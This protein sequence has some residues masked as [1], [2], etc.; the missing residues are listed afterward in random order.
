MQNPI[1][2]AG[3]R[4]ACLTHYVDKRLLDLASFSYPKLVIAG[5]RDE[6]L[7]QPVSSL[8]LA[9]QLKAELVIYPNGGHNLRLQDPKWQND[10][11]LYHFQ[12]AIDLKVKSTPNFI[13][14]S[15][16]LDSF[17]TA[18]FDEEIEYPFM[19]Q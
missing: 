13:S 9:K 5:D 18:E 4:N 6:L 10:K 16:S 17:V 14:K 8:Y 7:R 11:L 3:Q 12:K 19:D 1:G 15:E 2:R